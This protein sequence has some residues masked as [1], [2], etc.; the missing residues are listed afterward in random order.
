MIVIIGIILIAISNF[1]A[2]NIGYFL[3]GCGI[4]IPFIY[5]IINISL[6]FHFL[7]LKK[8]EKYDAQ[9]IIEFDGVDESNSNAGHKQ[10]TERE[11]KNLVIN[12]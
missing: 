5:L 10:I 1:I 11:D 8:H 2:K 12:F 9:H 4:I 6:I 7:K 3:G